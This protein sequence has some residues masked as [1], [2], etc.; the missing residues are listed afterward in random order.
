MQ[1]TEVSIADGCEETIQSTLSLHVDSLSFHRYQDASDSWKQLTISSV[2]VT[3]SSNIA[4]SSFLLARFQNDLILRV[5]VVFSSR[6]DRFNHSL[7]KQCDDP[8]HAISLLFFPR[9]LSFQLPLFPSSSSSIH[10]FSR[11]SFVRITRNALSRS[12]HFFFFFFFFFPCSSSFFFLQIGFVTIVA[13]VHAILSMVRNSRFPGHFPAFS[14]LLR[15]A[16]SFP[17]RSGHRH[18]YGSFAL[19]QPRSLHQPRP[20]RLLHRISPHSLSIRPFL[21]PSPPNSTCR[22]PRLPSFYRFL[23]TNSS[24]SP[25]S[26]SIAR[27]SLRAILPSS[28][29]G[30]CF[31][32][33]NPS[34]RGFFYSN[35]SDS[36]RIPSPSD[37]S[38]SK[39]PSWNCVSSTE[40]NSNQ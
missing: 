19:R 17:R 25:R 6:I 31:S 11:S 12:F 29:R 5:R 16:H 2:S 13:S 1:D 27:S 18:H 35:S 9:T 3:Y 7:S 40:H 21:A 37:P 8:P 32:A 23:P 26:P 38:D 24:S 39:S 10:S 20:L 15:S 34:D 36:N 30:F 33:R 4:K 22:S 28:I 14:E